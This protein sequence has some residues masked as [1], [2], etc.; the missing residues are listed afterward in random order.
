MEKVLAFVNHKHAG[1]FKGKTDAHKLM[2]R[3]L[4]GTDFQDKNSLLELLNKIMEA[5]DEDIDSSEKK[6]SDKEAFYKY[7]YGLDY[8]GVT[9]KL[10]V[11]DRNLDEL[12]PGERG[13][14]LLMFYL[15]LN[16]N[17]TPIIIDQPEDNLDN[18]SVYSKLVPCICAAKDRRQVIIVTH[19]PN[20]AVACD[21]EQIIYC[22]MD[23]NERCISY[24]A[25][26]IENEVI[27]QHVIDVL[28][29][30]M[31]AFDLRRRKYTRTES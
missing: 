19:N 7:L 8:I 29:G 9:F 11:G 22:D 15:A 6:I 3:L 21:A 4:K 2:E 28:E 5:V 16:K 24:S 27:K 18:Q 30:T 20:I 12:S 17:S 26:S 14:V 10:K 25:G 23:K 13:I 1:I 31:P